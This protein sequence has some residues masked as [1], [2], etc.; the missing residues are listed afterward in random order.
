MAYV[1]DLSIAVICSSNMNRS[2]EAHGYLAKKRFK[3]R[4]FGTG[5]KVKLPGTAADKPNVYEFG[6]SYDDIYNDLCNKDKQYYT[7]NGLLHMLDRNKRIKTA[8]E[9]FQLCTDR[10]DIIV[11][12]EERVYD[13]VIEYME[14]KMPIYNQPVH[15]INIDIQDNHEDATIGAF[16]VCDMI[17]QMTQ[18]E[19]LDN[20]VD[21]ILHDFETK[22]CRKLLHCVLFY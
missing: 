4:S 10:F 22:V 3:V 19:D 5:D 9:K 21:E 18:S 6:V 20:E 12:A 16:L 13:Q 11:T 15:V 17:T 8:T 1:S 14:S 2:M 7:Q